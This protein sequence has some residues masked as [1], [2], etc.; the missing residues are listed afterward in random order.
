M[1]KKIRR[2]HKIPIICIVRREKEYILD[3]ILNYSRAD[4]GHHIQSKRK[5]VR[6]C[7]Y[8]C[9]TTHM[10]SGIDRG[11]AREVGDSLLTCRTFSLEEIQLPFF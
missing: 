1:P 11:E 7:E 3:N 10:G 5:K 6:A 9:L 2:Q 8:S 4:Q